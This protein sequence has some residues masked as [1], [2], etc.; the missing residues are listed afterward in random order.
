SAPQRTFLNWIERGRRANPSSG[1]KGPTPSCVGTDR[2]LENV[3]RPKHLVGG[4]RQWRREG[5][6]IAHCRR[7]GQP[8]IQRGVHD[9]LREIIVR[10]LRGAILH[11]LD[12]EEQTAA[13]HIA[14]GGQLALHFLEAFEGDFADP[15]RVL[16]QIFLLDDLDRGESGSA[17]Y[18]V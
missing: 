6:N 14:D 15:A 9:R 8:A 2:F 16:D 17:R 18:R 7:E 13:A 4:Y 3:E 11:Q 10:L 1:K 5:Q 12:A